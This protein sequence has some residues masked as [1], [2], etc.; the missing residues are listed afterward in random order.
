MAL[1]LLGNVADSE[2][3]QAAYLI[4]RIHND[5]SR[6]DP[7]TAEQAVYFFRFAAR[8]GHAF[9]AFELAFLFYDA[10]SEPSGLASGDHDLRS[11]SDQY[12]VQARELFRT[13]ATIEDPEAERMLGLCYRF[14]WGGERSSLEAISWLTTAYE[15]GC[16]AAANDLCSIYYSDEPYIDND[17]ARFWFLKSKEHGCQVFEIAE[18]E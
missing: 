3:I 8:H 4:G 7:K 9:A 10:A 1:E 6:H 13:G 2:K 5:R 14:G 18:F 15:H 17:T 11:Q 12:L 16:H